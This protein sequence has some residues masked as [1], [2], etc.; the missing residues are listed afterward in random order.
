[1]STNVTPT[2]VDANSFVLILME[3][4]IALVT[5]EWFYSRMATVKVS[6]S[7]LS[8]IKTQLNNFQII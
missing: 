1:M 4:I 3:D 6:D 7:I 8:A 5:K 2:K